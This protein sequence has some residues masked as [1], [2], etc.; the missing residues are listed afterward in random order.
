MSHPP[1]N[2]V[3]KK[4]RFEYEILETFEAGIV[5]QGTE[6]KSVRERRVNFQDAYCYFKRG[7]LWCKGI[8]ISEYSHGGRWNHDPARD[9][10]LLMKK[11]ELRR[12]REKVQEKGMTL[13]P[14]RL[15]INRRGWVKVEL[16]L[17]R[18]KKKYDKRE[19]IRRREQ[20]IEARRTLKKWV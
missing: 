19:T 12:L 15:Y 3:N 5:L 4:A 14:L 1:V 11:R 10:K 9:R 2:I 20:E 16:A 17:V 18:G 7:E 6:V 13:V 8:H